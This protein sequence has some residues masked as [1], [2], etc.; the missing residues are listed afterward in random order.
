MSVIND[1][2]RDLEARKAPEREAPVAGVV[3]DIIEPQ[4]ER[5]RLVKWLPVL[6]IV[7]CAG[8]LGVYG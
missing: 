7:L 5:P 4:A 6:L 1:M 8:A 3:A 2:L